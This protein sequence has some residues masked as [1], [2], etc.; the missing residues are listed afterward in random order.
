MEKISIRE[1]RKLA[2]IEGKLNNLRVRVRTSLD[3][4]IVEIEKGDNKE[5][6]D[7]LVVKLKQLI[8]Y[9]ARRLET[10]NTDTYSNDYRYYSNLYCN[11]L[12]NNCRKINF[13]SE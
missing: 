7:N 10:M 9:E 4:V 3:Y 5:K 13:W 1:F 8:C 2:K 12:I 11:Q 6:F